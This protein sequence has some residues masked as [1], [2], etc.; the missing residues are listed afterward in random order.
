MSGRLHHVSITCASLTASLAFYRQ[1]GFT[2]EQQYQ[3]EACSIVL[4]HSQNT[5]IELFVFS[6]TVAPQNHETL[7]Y[8]KAIGLR[9]L[10]IEV[11][12]VAKMHDKLSLTTTVT[13]IKQARLGSFNYFFCYDPDGNQV[14]VLNINNGIKGII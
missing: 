10:A 4:L 9:H 11:D 3:D 2:V 1:F 14:E 8:L 5:H 6:D 13:P 12:N 7:I